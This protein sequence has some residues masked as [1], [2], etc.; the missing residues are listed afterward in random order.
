MRIDRL[1]LRA[2]G[3]FTDVSLDLSNGKQGL[4]LI[5][6]LNEAGKSS[7]L[8]ALRLMFFG[9]DHGT[10]DDFVHDKQKLRIGATLRNPDGATLAFLRRK[11][12]KRTLRS[13]LDDADLDDSALAPF[14]GRLTRERF[15]NLF[16]FDHERLARGGLEI[17]NGGGDPEQLIFG[18]ASDL[19][20]LR[21]VQKDL[22]KGWSEIFKKTGRNPPLNEALAELAEIRQAVEAASIRSAEW[23]ER[24]ASLAEA[25]RLERQAQ[26]ELDDLRRRTSRLERIGQALPDLARRRE[27]LNDLSALADA[28]LLRADFAEVRCKIQNEILLA[29]QAD[30]LSKSE[31][32]EIE[33]EL[34]AL[35]VPEPLLDAAERIDALHVQFGSLPKQQRDMAKKRD[36]HQAA[37]D[38]ARDHLRDLGF[39]DDLGQAESLRITA[40]T[41]K[42]IINFIDNYPALFKEC[43]STCKA[44]DVQTRIIDDLVVEIDA[45]EGDRN[46]ADLRAA[47]ERA[48]RKGD[49]HE[50]ADAVRKDLKKLER[51]ANDALRKLSLWSGPLEDVE[52]LIVPKGPTIDRHAQ[53][54]DAAKAAVTEQKRRIAEQQD[55]IHELD[56]KLEQQ[57]LELALPTEDD[58]AEARRQRD[59][60]WQRIRNLRR[61]GP[62]DSD[63]LTDLANTFEHAVEQAD[64][65]ADR[66]L[67]GASSVAERTRWQAERQAAERKLAILRLELLDVQ[68]RRQDVKERWAEEWRPLGINPRSPR[69]ML[70][71]TTEQSGVADKARQVR[72]SREKLDDLVLQ[73]NAHLDALGNALHLLGEPA[74]QPEESLPDLLDRAQGVIDQIIQAAN[75]RQKKQERLKEAR[76]T[77][78]KAK[79]ED[80]TARNAFTKWKDGWSNLLIPLG[81]P[82]ETAPEDARAFLEQLKEIEKANA[83]RLEI[84]AFEQD[85]AQLADEAQTL[86]L[87][88]APE[89]ADL[90]A[91]LAVKTLRTRLDAARKQQ[92][93]QEGLEAR[94]TQK[95]DQGKKARA[96]IAALT[97]Q[98]DALCR[99]VGC[100]S[101]ADLPAVEERSQQRRAFEDELIAV[102]IRLRALSGG[103]TVEAF[104]FEADQIDPDSIQSCIGR[105]REQIADLTDVRDEQ[106]RRIGEEETKLNAMDEQARSAKALEALARKH[107]QLTKIGSETERYVR[108]RLASAMLRD[109]VA[110]YAKQN[111]GSVLRRAGLLFKDL[112]CGG[113]DGLR[114]ELNDSDKTA[115]VGTRGNG[116]ETVRVDQM[117]DGTRDQLYLSLKLASVEHH[118]DSN[119][120]IPFIVDDILVHFDDSRALAALRA[121]AELSKRTQVLFFTHHEHLINLARQGLGPGDLFIHELRGSRIGA[122]M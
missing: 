107:S 114:T 31:L 119:P 2:F 37:L 55:N 113:F 54:F 66:L 76:V 110:S 81:L 11:G 34:D 115:L 75:I 26:T 120:P 49:L 63:P 28:R 111:Q 117:S 96:D 78:K 19:P 32:Q 92:I 39:G 41:S 5:Y 70:A 27:L 1:D 15:E 43:E 102:Q 40:S 47:V 67:R 116:G 12:N 60:V 69:E 80:K 59:Q 22:E 74:A 16:G 112:T 100:A 99:E 79:D 50:Q 9:F 85:R 48:N 98:L 64:S 91:T 94:R 88:I 87:Q 13:A 21:E 57:R 52:G 71:W 10:S 61:D 104:A 33:Q 86:T 46:P 83:L 25:R 35:D 106:I 65:L 6:G 30:A 4:H 93:R 14:F 42:R 84:D 58:L 23:S 97:E 53:E 29:E 89:L 122:T 45:L 109:A 24:T 17:A 20:R 73:A 121:M 36:Q 72:E 68:A 101:A 56:L 108:L 103:Q 8:R 118:L 38:S 18:A 105:L 7:A 3:P 77:L 90:D 51:Q 82:A 44:I 95:H 62:T